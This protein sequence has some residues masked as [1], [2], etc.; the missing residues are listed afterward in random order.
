MRK[1]EILFAMLLIFPVLNGCASS[2][3]QNENKEID[4]IILTSFS[5]K[6]HEVTVN[7]PDVYKLQAFLNSNKKMEGIINMTAPDYIVSAIYKDNR[8]DKYHLWVGN[9]EETSAIS[10]IDNTESLYT[11]SSEATQKIQELMKANEN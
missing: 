3:T 5:D 8:E 7:K 6:S 4:K 2:S 10:E 9:K 11:L 1:W